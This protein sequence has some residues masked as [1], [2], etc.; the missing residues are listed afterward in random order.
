MQIRL[1]V[2][3]TTIGVRFPDMTETY[4]PRLRTLAGQKAGEA[5]ICN[6]TKACY[7]AVLGPSYEK[8]AEIRY[9]RTI[10]AD[11]VPGSTPFARSNCGEPSWNG[12]LGIS[13]VTNLAAGLAGKKLDHSEVLETGRRVSTTFLTLA[14]ALLPTLV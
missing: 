6:C 9:L 7:A 11:L 14:T 10:G 12:M 2:Q 5:G 4:S 13:C 1:W 8:P 3:T